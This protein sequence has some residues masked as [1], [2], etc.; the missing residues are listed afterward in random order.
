MQETVLKARKLLAEKIIDKMEKRQ[1]EACYCETKEEALEKVKGYFTDGA[2]ITSGGSVSLGEIGLTDYLKSEEAGRKYNFIDRGLAK[3]AEEKRQV[4]SKAALADYYL[5]S[6]N[7]FTV[8][9]ELV[10][11]DGAGNRVAALCFGPSNVIIVLSMNKVCEDV[12]S[13]LWRVRNLAAP[14]NA[15]RLGIDT[16]CTEIGRCANCLKPDCICA[17]LVVTRFS[18]VPKRIKVVLVGEDLGY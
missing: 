11:I 6:T 1:F 2:T 8:D 12:D 18:R 16:L 7:A 15:A 17:Q 13:A 10:N 5:M 14:P 9:G 4:F 3:T